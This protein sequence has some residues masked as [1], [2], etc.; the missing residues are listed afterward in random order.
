M[1]SLLSADHGEELH[2]CG[3]GPGSRGALPHVACGQERLDHR[4]LQRGPPGRVLE[5]GVEHRRGLGVPGIPP[6]HVG[7]PDPAVAQ[8]HRASGH[9]HLT[10]VERGS[11]APGPTPHHHEAGLGSPQDPVGRPRFEPGPCRLHRRRVG[12][13]QG[14]H[15]ARPRRVRGRHW[16]IYFWAASFLA[17]SF[18]SRITWY[19]PSAAGTKPPNQAPISLKTSGL[20]AFIVVNDSVIAERR[21]AGMSLRTTIGSFG[22]SF[23]TQMTR[24]AP[25]GTLFSRVNWLRSGML[26]EAISTFLFATARIEASWEPENVIFEKYFFGS[27]PMSIMKKAEGTR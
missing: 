14:R 25:R 17:T 3:I 15:P 21:L 4:R 16:P 12:L 26:V 5:H 7:V 20:R 10:Q 27:T 19:F 18:R 8:L 23:D 1:G 22:M 11:G 13:G 24:S 9:R 2:P 6:G